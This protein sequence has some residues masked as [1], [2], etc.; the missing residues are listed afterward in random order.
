MFWDKWHMF[1]LSMLGPEFIFML[2][3]GQYMSAQAS[4]KAF[5]ESGHKDWTIRHSFYANMGGF[6]FRPRGWKKFPID[7][8]QLHYLIVHGYIGYPAVDRLSIEDKN[9]S[10][11]LAR[12]VKFV[13]VRASH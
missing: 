9:K 3:L 11:G 8:K 12:C 5:H 13:T 6:V 4:R 1:C 10:D 2:A 7:A